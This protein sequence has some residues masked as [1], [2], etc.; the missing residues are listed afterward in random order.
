VEQVKIRMHEKVCAVLEERFISVR[1]I[2]NLV[3]AYRSATFPDAG[4][5]IT[6][7]CRVAAMQ[8]ADTWR[9]RRKRS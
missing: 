3:R 4:S 6:D 8:R 5:Q 2:D 9:T 1:T 7:E